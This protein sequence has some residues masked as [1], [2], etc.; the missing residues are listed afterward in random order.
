MGYH[1]RSTRSAPTDQSAPKIKGQ[2]PIAVDFYP[3][4]L[5]GLLPGTRFQGVK[6]PVHSKIFMIRLVR[7]VT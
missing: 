1:L 4:T 6:A 3:D 7:T 2:D 5:E